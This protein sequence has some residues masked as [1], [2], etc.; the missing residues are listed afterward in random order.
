MRALKAGLRLR[1]AV[2]TAEVMVIRVP[3][4]EYDLRCG[5]AP[6]LGAG[7]SAVDAVVIDPSQAGGA[8]VGK[9]YV[10]AQERLELLCTKSG[11]G[12]LTLNGAALLLKQAQ[13][14]PSSD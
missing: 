10:D 1:S 8:R 6:M 11:N 12:S 5:G 3:A 7:E 4:G 13:A 2:C 14:L 9:R